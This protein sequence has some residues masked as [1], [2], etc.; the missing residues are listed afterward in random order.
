MKWYTNLVQDG[1][2]RS[3][4]EET[5][6][7]V[8]KCFLS[9]RSRSRDRAGLKIRQWC[10]AFPADC[11]SDRAQT[12]FKRYDLN[13]YWT[14]SCTFAAHTYMCIVSHPHW[15]QREHARLVRATMI[16]GRGLAER[17]RQQSAHTSVPRPVLGLAG[18]F[19]P[20]CTG[21]YVPAFVSELDQARPLRWS[22]YVHTFKPS[23]RHT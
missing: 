15:Q 10:S 3:R 6:M 14:C 8:R 22:R 5:R 13:T 2:R 20:M 17:R 19:A 1:S 18:A 12:L 16:C 11:A 23:E 7:H 4:P 9:T 21:T